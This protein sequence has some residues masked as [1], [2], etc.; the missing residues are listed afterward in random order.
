MGQLTDSEANALLDYKFGAGANDLAPATY[1]VGLS[2]TTP[3]ADGTNITEPSGGS[4]ARVAV[5]NNSTNWPAASSRVK[6]NGTVITF[7][8]ATG[9]WGSVTDFFLAD[10]S[11]AGNVLAYGELTTPQTVTSTGTPSFG[12]DVLEINV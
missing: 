1:Y 8:T 2:L 10:A 11:T 12:V 3:A 9:T 5:T 4:Y 6:S 7:P